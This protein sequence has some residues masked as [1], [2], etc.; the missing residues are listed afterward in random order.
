[1]A[2]D[3]YSILKGQVYSDACIHSAHTNESAKIA[4]FKDVY[5]VIM[6]D[7]DHER[8]PFFI[9]S[10]SRILSEAQRQ[11][12]LDGLAREYAGVDGWMAYV[13]RECS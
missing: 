5:D 1:M 10:I 8:Q 13:D 6:S 3:L 2:D 11:V 9:V 4:G 12:L 7:S